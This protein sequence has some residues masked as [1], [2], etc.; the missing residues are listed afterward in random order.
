MNAMQVVRAARGWAWIRA[1]FALFRAQPLVWVALVF[2]YWSMMNLIGLVPYVGFAAGLVL[3]PLFAVSFMNIARAAERGQRPE[4][5]MLFSGFRERPK[6]LVVLGIVYLV[7]H[8]V[9]LLVV[10]LTSP[11][12]DGAADMRRIG[13]GEAL[14]RAVDESALLRTA[15]LAT[16]FY[17]PI[18][19]AYWFAPV[20]V[21]WDRM[22]P[23][24]ALF[25]S[26]FSVTAN[27]RAFLVYGAAVACLAAALLGVVLALVSLVAGGGSG[28]GPGLIRIAAPVYVATL[29][30]LLFASFYASY[31]EVFPPPEDSPKPLLEQGHPPS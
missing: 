17:I 3:V 25:F 28:G 26:F 18:V 22:T 5:Q 31:R 27:W 7:L 29:M 9:L 14:N 11:L 6:P 4:F 8:V 13:E 23:G 19:A 10:L 16:A 24:K 21:A 1:G 12:E 2:G 15:L 20:L 30:P